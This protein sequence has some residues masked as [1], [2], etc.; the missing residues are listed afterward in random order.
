MERHI[1]DLIKKVFS[2]F[3]YFL[4]SMQFFLFLLESFW[5]YE[6][7][8]D[9]VILLE[10]AWNYNLSFIAEFR[11]CNWSRIQNV[12]GLLK[13]FEYFWRKS[14]PRTHERTYWNHWRTSWF[15]CTVQCECLFHCIDN[16]V[17]VKE[18]TFAAFHYPMY[19]NGVDF[20][21]LMWYCLISLVKW[22][23]MDMMHL[24]YMEFRHILFI[25]H[26]H[27]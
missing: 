15:R 12:Y 16:Q 11:R 8:F 19:N 6:L 7:S 9:L 14:S 13:E 3:Y 4:L 1:T 2:W 25:V 17:F 21:E 27:L 22:W 23:H 10:D 18:V 20:L 26:M 5:N 24:I